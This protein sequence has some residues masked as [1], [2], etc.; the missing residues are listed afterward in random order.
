MTLTWVQTPRFWGEPTP[1][2]IL[3]RRE[4]R[5]NLSAGALVFLL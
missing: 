4:L 2:D 1:R 3:P 5:V